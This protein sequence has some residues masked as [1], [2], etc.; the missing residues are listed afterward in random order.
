MSLP[1]GDVKLC[2]TGQVLADRGGEHAGFVPCGRHV[3]EEVDRLE[4]HVSEVQSA[5]AAV[6]GAG[7][8][9][10]TQKMYVDGKV[11]W[12]LKVNKER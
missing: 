5:L 9:G 1:E 2:R 7:E 12:A 11:T 6:D 4:S 10:V 3:D 8:A